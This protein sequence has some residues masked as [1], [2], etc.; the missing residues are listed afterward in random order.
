MQSHFFF[1][2][3]EMSGWS[4]CLLSAFLAF[5]LHLVKAHGDAAY[6]LLISLYTFDFLCGLACALVGGTFCPAKFKGGIKK[7]ADTFC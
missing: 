2:C 3:P 1:D 4:R 5:A 7:L 6:W